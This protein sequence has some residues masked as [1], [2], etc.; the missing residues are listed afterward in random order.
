MKQN[1]IFLVF[2]FAFLTMVLVGCSHS[3]TAETIQVTTEIEEP[4]AAN[5]RDIELKDVLTGES[6][7]ISD[8]K[9]KPVLLESMAVWCPTCTQQQKEIQK[10]HK[11]VGD[12]VV[13]IS[14][15]TDPNE[16][17]A[18]L[19]DY[20]LGKGFEWRFA[21]SPVPLTKGLI[22]EFGITVVNAPSAP[23][24][25]IC[26]DLSTRMLKGGVKSANTLKSEIEKGC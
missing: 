11:E 20:V 5:W 3:E 1:K 14:L 26:E 23:V 21:I 22:N 6:F 8:F 15:D 4:T 13:S 9:G 7:K 12:A 24:V 17:E 18:K 16:D 10:L 19:K 2:A 25:L